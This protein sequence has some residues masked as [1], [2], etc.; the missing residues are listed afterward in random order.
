MRVWTEHAAFSAPA[1]AGFGLLHSR[2]GQKEDLHL[3][4]FKS[5]AG[6]FVP[7]KF[8]FDMEIPV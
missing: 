5:P 1:C 6:F 7:C 8:L 3:Q 2:S 4:D